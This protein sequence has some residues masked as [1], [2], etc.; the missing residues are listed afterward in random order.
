[1]TLMNQW[2]DIIAYR[3]FYDVPRIF[4]VVVDGRT[5]LF[6]CPFDEALDE[7]PYDYRVYQ[8][9]GLGIHELPH[10]WNELLDQQKADYRGSVPVHN[11]MFDASKRKQIKCVEL[12]RLIGPNR[13]TR[14]GDRSFQQ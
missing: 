1:M 10:D 13:D 3:D 8:L 4:L 2:I 14:N 7:Y 9:R 6:D 11:V 12:G 5:V